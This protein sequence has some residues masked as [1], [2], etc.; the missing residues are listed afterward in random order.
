MRSVEQAS[1]IEGN[2]ME[3]MVSVA[4]QA[5]KVMDNGIKLAGSTEFAPNFGRIAF[6][7]MKEIVRREGLCCSII[8]G[9]PLRGRISIGTKTLSKACISFRNVSA[10]EVNLFFSLFQDF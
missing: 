2:Q 4:K 8:D 6:K 1:Y 10:C 3:V 5:E 7:T 9:L